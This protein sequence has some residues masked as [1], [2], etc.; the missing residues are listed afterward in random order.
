MTADIATPR[1]VLL[2]IAP[3]CHAATL[4]SVS[5]GVPADRERV[6]HPIAAAGFEPAGSV[7]TEPETD[8]AAVP[9]AGDTGPCSAPA[10]LGCAAE[11]GHDA[12][13]G[14][15][16]KR[17]RES[18]GALHQCQ[19]CDQ[20]IATPHWRQRYCSG[21]CPVAAHRAGRRAVGGAS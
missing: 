6:L 17:A 15:D 18:I 12:E 14:S 20:P 5:P 1:I 2:R 13:S 4:P 11:R 9:M 3:R 7:E 10:P 16:T 19:H 21:R 8:G